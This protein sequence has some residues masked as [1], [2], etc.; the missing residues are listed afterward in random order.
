[1]SLRKPAIAQQGMNHDKPYFSSISDVNV[2]MFMANYYTFFVN[3]TSMNTRLYGIC[4]KFLWFLLL[5]HS[6]WHTFNRIHKFLVG[7]YS[8]LKPV[9]VL[10]RYFQM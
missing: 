3:K 10:K 2:L 4:F 6:C 1:M 5:L 8:S 9:T 7:F